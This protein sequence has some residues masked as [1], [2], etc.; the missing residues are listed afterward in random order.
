MMDPVVLTDIPLELD[1]GALMDKFRLKPGSPR[2]EGIRRLSEEASG[3]G[4]PRAV[5]RPCAIEARG[6]DRIE[7]GGET[8][9]SRVLAVNL[10]K[11]HRVFPFAATCGRELESWSRSLDGSLETFCA[12]EIKGMALGAAVLTLVSHL[13]EHHCPGELSMM[14]PGS[15]EDWPLSEQA[16]L[17]RIL[18]DPVESVLGVTL[19]DSFL[20]EPGMTASGI[21]FPWIGRLSLVR[22]AWFR[23][24]SIPM[25]L[26]RATSDMTG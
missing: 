18:G 3:L 17:F 7:L 24:D 9:R 5:F 20:M 22:T 4:R 16:P 6:E 19:L 14:N 25:S 15:L 12:E 10:E 11:V 23:Y 1:P 8:F 21:W 2:G 26:R 13:Q